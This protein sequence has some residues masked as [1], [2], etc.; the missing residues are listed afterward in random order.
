MSSHTPSP[1][2][3]PSRPGRNLTLSVPTSNMS[4]SAVLA[5]RSPSMLNRALSGGSG[6]ITAP[7]TPLAVEA[8]DG[9]LS[10]KSLLSPG[11]S[12][13]S[14]RRLSLDLSG[15]DENGQP[16]VTS[17]NSTESLSN[18]PNH[19]PLGSRPALIRLSSGTR[20][21]K[22]NTTTATAATSSSST[23]A[24]TANF[25]SL[26]PALNVTSPSSSTILSSLTASNNAGVGAVSL[27]SP[28]SLDDL[29]PTPN[30]KAFE[31]G[32]Q[33][34]Y[35]QTEIAHQKKQRNRQK[36]LRTGSQ[37]NLDRLVSD[38]DIER[39]RL[40]MAAGQSRSNVGAGA[41]TN[42]L[43]R[44]EYE[45]SYDEIH[46]IGAP[47]SAVD[48]PTLNRSFTEPPS[49]RTPIHGSRGVIN[50]QP[51]TLTYTSESIG[52]AAAASAEATAAAHEQ[53]NEVEASRRNSISPQASGL[54]FHDDEDEQKGDR[55]SSAL[56]SPAGPVPSL[57]RNRS[58]NH[59]LGATSLSA[60]EIPAY[61]TP[62]GQVSPSTPSSSSS[63]SSRHSRLLVVNGPFSNSRPPSHSPSP[64]PSPKG[65]RQSSRQPSPAPVRRDAN[66]AN[67]FLSPDSNSVSP[68]PSPRARR[69]VQ[70]NDAN[71]VSSDGDSSNSRLTNTNTKPTN[72]RSASTGALPKSVYKKPAT[73]HI[74]VH[75]AH[76]SKQAL[77]SSQGQSLHPT[78]PLP[79]SLHAPF[80]SP[81]ALL[82]LQVALFHDTVNLDAYCITVTRTGSILIKYNQ[83]GKP[84]KRWFYV[85]ETNDEVKLCWSEPKYSKTKPLWEVNPNGLGF[86][87]HIED[88]KEAHLSTQKLTKHKSA[89]S[90]S[91]SSSSSSSHSHHLFPAFTI[92]KWKFNQE[93]SRSLLEVSGIHYGPYYSANFCRFL[94]KMDSATGKPWLCFSVQFKDRTID[95][96]C[97]NE[98]EV[99]AWFLGLQAQAPQTCFYM[100]RGMILWQ[101]LIM[102][103]RQCERSQL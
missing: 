46:A 30:G 8:L 101:R 98:H 11:G 35:I 61:R 76:V 6:K 12:L 1:S 19:R 75:M 100:T 56:P 82:R 77:S 3:S 91:S 49:R 90:S 60:L 80:A 23:A 93:R 20:A 87:P 34:I 29:Q 54:R 15:L 59:R 33:Q 4:N 84:M 83:S 92:G 73:H 17:S 5:P 40:R 66:E 31:S 37:T 7:L 102:K 97:S 27:K 26:P 65:S 103:V 74:S 55:E 44:A 86:Q 9:T 64:Q 51:I 25:G 42:S 41:G 62:S 57:M 32:F 18:S 96:V 43:T 36:V 22:G 89:A 16:I 10:K 94:D 21:P 39:D 78:S 68:S 53:A 71:L 14:T 63:T 38:D 81:A 58:N 85:E 72:R 47:A 50:T 28:Q 88:E 79:F 13:N 67:R 95:L 2:P 69:R 99:T 52:V 70:F 48:R 24:T 45:D